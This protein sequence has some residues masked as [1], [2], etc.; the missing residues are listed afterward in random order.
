MDFD[1]SR[2]TRAVRDFVIPLFIRFYFFQ[3]RLGSSETNLVKPQLD[4]RSRE[5]MLKRDD[6]RDPKRTSRIRASTIRSTIDWLAA[7]PWQYGAGSSAAR[8]DGATGR[9]NGCN[10]TT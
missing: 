5:A 10:G 8:N 2:A 6:S 4:S 7:C 1:I 3:Q 9:I